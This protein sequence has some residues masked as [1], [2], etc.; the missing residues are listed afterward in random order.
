MH[1]EVRTRRA[2]PCLDDRCRSDSGSTQSPRRWCPTSLEARPSTPPT[3]HTASA[4][5]RAEHHPAP[6]LWTPPRPAR[7]G[8]SL[9]MPWLRVGSYRPARARHSLKPR[10]RSRALAAESRRSGPGRHA[11]ASQW[12]RRR[13][14]RRS[15]R[16][17]LGAWH[18]AA[19]IRPH[20]R[21]PQP[22]A[23]HDLPAASRR[24]QRGQR[25][26]AR[27]ARRRHEAPDAPKHT[28]L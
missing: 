18:R 21:L 10:A 8:A 27:R 16:A 13:D 1:C 7:S 3:R 17:R 22:A 6:R 14:G 24:A 28:G 19:R 11:I 26:P 20:E 15:R 4:H 2:R 12:R 23:R 9:G 5:L 25:Q